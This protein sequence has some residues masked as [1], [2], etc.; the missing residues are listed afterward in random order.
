MFWPICP[1]VLLAVKMTTPL[2]ISWFWT[3][4]STIAYDLIIDLPLSLNWNSVAFSFHV[5]RVIL[6]CSL[7]TLINV[8]GLHKFIWKTLLWY[9]VCCSHCSLFTLNLYFS[10]ALRSYCLEPFSS[11]FHKECVICHGGLQ[12]RQKHKYRQ[13]IRH[14]LTSL[15]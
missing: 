10:F 4:V 2:T 7:H 5:G 11:G 14:T 3:L 9:L 8:C 1:S 6:E 12:H 15:L 13:L